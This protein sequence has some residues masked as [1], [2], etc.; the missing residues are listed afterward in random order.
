MDNL[1][2]YPK[3]YRGELSSGASVEPGD[4]YFDRL[5]KVL[6]YRV[7]NT[8]RFRGGMKDPARARF[9]IRLMFQ[10]LNGN[11]IYDRDVEH[12]EGARLVALEP[13]QWV[14]QQPVWSATSQR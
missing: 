14:N 11:G 10:D 7:R 13:Y 8:E 12:L 4:W 5:N 3:N 1:D 2:R 6:V 9:A